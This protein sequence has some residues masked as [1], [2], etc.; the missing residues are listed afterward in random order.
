MASS[1]SAN[2]NGAAS[3]GQGKT[4]LG[5]TPPIALNGPTPRELEVTD[6]LVEELKKRNVFETAQENKLRE[7]VLGKLD[8]MVKDFVYKAS[9][10]KGMSE[11]LAKT[12]GGKIFTFGS[13]RLGV[14]SPGSDID[15]LCVVPKH[16][17][18][19]DFFSIFL[20]ML[21]ARP[22]ATEIA[23]VPDAY[24]PL[25]GA[26]FSGIA[27]DF[28]FSRL[29]LPRVDDA[30]TLED[31]NLLRN[32]DDKD[33]RSLGGSRVTDAILGLVPNV[34]TF[35]MALRCIKLWAQS[36]FRRSCDPMAPS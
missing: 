28:T 17:Q 23:P 6:S 2:G 24:V 14:H 27:I 7:V 1:Y 22:E 9:L 11:S 34:P 12:A 25:I 36:E 10:T 21:K 15:T 26:K 32:L 29:P 16:V 5:V 20:D 35:H 8:A 13:Y 18:R 31:S 30:L 4:Y 33:V 3:V 19:E